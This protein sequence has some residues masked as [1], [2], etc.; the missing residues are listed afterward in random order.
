MA[1]IIT[2]HCGILHRLWKVRKWIMSF[3]YVVAFVVLDDDDNTAG[4]R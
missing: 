4:F 3:T 1:S 2:Y